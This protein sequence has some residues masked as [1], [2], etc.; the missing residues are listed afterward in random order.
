[1]ILSQRKLLWQLGLLHKHGQAQGIRMTPFDQ[2]DQQGHANCRGQ[3]GPVQERLPILL[4]EGPK[5]KVSQAL[6]GP[7]RVWD[8]KDTQP[9]LQE[10]DTLTDCI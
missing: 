8:V 4:V 6:L 3:L 2:L 10:V 1:M 7:R 9:H 5:D